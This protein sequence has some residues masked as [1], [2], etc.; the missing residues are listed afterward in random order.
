MFSKGNKTTGS[1]TPTP[2]PATP[3]PAP[4]PVSAAAPPKPQASSVPSI[5]SSDLKI[6]GNMHSNG[7]IQIDGQVEGDVMSRTLTIGEGALVKGSVRGETVRICGQVQGEVNAASVIIAKTARVSGD[8]VHQSLAIEAGAYLEG[9]I[10]RME[11]NR[12]AGSAAS[13]PVLRPGEGLGVGGGM[14]GG[15]KPA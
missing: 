1:P 2:A 6:V 5:I 11:P 10:R 14:G 7:D 13:A 15:P 12:P 4:A 8:V 3:A 9:N